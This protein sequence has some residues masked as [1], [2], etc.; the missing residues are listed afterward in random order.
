MED[1]NIT[2]RKMSM[3]K[4]KYKPKKTGKDCA[5]KKWTSSPVTF[6][7]VSDVA[8]FWDTANF[9]DCANFPS[10]KYKEF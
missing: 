10:N 7:S 5:L 8:E 2:T 1:P 6:T 9:Q 4:C 3:H